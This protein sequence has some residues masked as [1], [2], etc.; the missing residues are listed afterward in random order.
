MFNESV[1]YSISLALD[2]EVDF[3]GEAEKAGL[4][5]GEAKGDVYKLRITT[6]TDTVSGV[7]VSSDGSAWEEVKWQE[8]GS[9]TELSAPAGT[10]FVKLCYE[11]DD[12]FLPILIAAV[13]VCVVVI[14]AVVLLVRRR[15]KKRVS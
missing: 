9:Y 13:G 6:P 1:I 3:D 8:K 10:R 15:K 4:P 11:N 12:A 2:N 5:K 7:F 14:L